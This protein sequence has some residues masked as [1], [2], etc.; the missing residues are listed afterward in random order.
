MPPERST[1]ARLL[2]IVIKSGTDGFGAAE[3]K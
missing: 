3:V 2:I 1:I